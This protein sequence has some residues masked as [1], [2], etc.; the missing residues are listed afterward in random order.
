MNYYIHTF[1]SEKT[2]IYNK[3]SSTNGDSVYPD[4]LF[5]HPFSEAEIIDDILYE[6][7]KNAIEE[8]GSSNVIIAAAANEND[9]NLLKSRMDFLYHE[10]DKTD[11]SELIEKMSNYLKLTESM[12]I[13]FIKLLSYYRETGSDPADL[14][15]PFIDEYA[16]PVTNKNEGK[17]IYEL[18]RNKILG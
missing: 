5:S 18:I 15:I 16:L 2:I 7:V 17:K 11:D 4:V 9:I 10:D 12:K 8:Y 13:N 1:K 3:V 6:T 14:I